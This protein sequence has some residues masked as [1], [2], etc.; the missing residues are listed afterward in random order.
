MSTENNTLPTESSIDPI[1][2]A[3]DSIA[4]PQSTSTNETSSVSEQG[5]DIVDNI[6][7][8]L[9]KASTPEPKPKEATT[10][11]NDQS[12]TTDDLD[13]IPDKP[14]GKSTPEASM[15][16][17]EIRA[18]IKQARAREA[19]LLQE[20]EEAKKNNTID[21]DIIEKAKF[22]DEAERQLAL[23]KIEATREFKN[24]VNEP[25][26]AIA[27]AA[28]NIATRHGI[29]VDALYEALA[30]SDITKRNGLFEDILSGVPDADRYSIY[31]MAIDTQ[32]IFN[33][34][35]QLHAQAVEARKELDSKLAAE[36]EKEKAAFRQK[37]NSSIET[38]A[39]SLKKVIPFIDLEDGDTADSFYSDLVSKATSSDFNTSA[40]NVQAFSVVS[41][42]MIPRLA[43]QIA[44]LS[45]RAATAESRV[46]ELTQG[47]PGTR[48]PKTSTETEARR[49]DDWIDNIMQNL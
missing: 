13:G 17:G 27:T 35:D 33:K 46:S 39:E 12:G 45:E 16:W 3:M 34:R 24:V 48:A 19:Q 25:L 44:A 37:L 11:S 20:L 15:K 42:L 49:S 29:D 5:V 7:A 2:D 14:P 18:E 21:P 4:E 40:P 10:D 28:E 22:A 26:E 31:Q 47:S 43:K 38:T 1:A 23:T 32:T 30:E 9:N 41:A 8:E 6:M 36:T